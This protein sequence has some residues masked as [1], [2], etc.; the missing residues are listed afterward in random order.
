MDKIKY[1]VTCSVGENWFSLHFSK[2]FINKV[3]EG[4]RYIVSDTMFFNFGQAFLLSVLIVYAK[5]YLVR[6]W[7]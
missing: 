3:S 6:M 5:I 4:M 1:F 7:V 2:L